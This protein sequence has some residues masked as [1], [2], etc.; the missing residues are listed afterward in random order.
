M[1]GISKD[2]NVAGGVSI[3]ERKTPYSASAV[4]LIRR[5]ARS[6]TALVIVGFVGICVAT[7]LAARSRDSE[8]R[9]TSWT[10]AISSLSIA[11]DRLVEVV[12]DH[13]SRHPGPQEDPDQTRSLLGDAPHRVYSIDHVFVFDRDGT[14]VFQSHAPEATSYK[15]FDQ[16]HV[17]EALAPLV[18][19][20]RAAANTSA[21]TA[22]VW[23]IRIFGRVHLAGAAAIQADGTKDAAPDN[24]GSVL[25]F[26][27][28]FLPSY[29]DRI[30]GR[31]ALRGLRIA[32]APNVS[33]NELALPLR[34]RDP[35]ET[36]GY[37]IWQPRLPGNA[38]INAIITPLLMT[39]AL[40]LVLL[41]LVLRWAKRVGASLDSASAEVAT[42]R[43]SLEAE[44][45]VRNA[46]LREAEARYRGIV[47]NAVEGI[48]QL[49][50]SGRFISANPAMARILGYADPNQLIAKAHANVMLNAT[51]RE[52]FERVIATF[53]EVVDF[54]SEVHRRDGSRT[55]ISQNTRAVRDKAGSIAYYEGTVVDIT[56]R[57]EAEENLIKN[58]F[59]DA[60]TGLPNRFLFFERLNQLI[61]RG[62]RSPD[63]AFA[64]LFLDC[65]RFKL[66][67]DS[68]GH[69]AGDNLLITLAQRL[70]QRLRPA[71]TLARLGG[72][73]F[74]ILIE[75][76][77]MPTNALAFA[78]RLHEACHQ[79]MKLE[80]RDVYV[81]ISIGIAFA[82][83]GRYSEA[84]AILRDADIAMYKAKDAGRGT[85]VLFEPGM[86]QA[87][88]SRLEVE[89]QLRH[90]LDRGG[91]VVYYQ[92]IISLKDHRVAGF[93][94]LVRW[95]HLTRGLVLPSEFIPTAEET[96]MIVPIGN[97]VLREACAFAASWRRYHGAAANNLFMSVNVS[98]AQLH[99][100]G[101]AG[102]IAETLSWSGLPG[103]NLKLEITESTMMANPL[104]VHRTLTDIAALGVRLCVD[105]FGT[106]YSS[107]SHLHT[108]P[109]STLKI[110]RAFTSRL[111]AG[112]EHIE[113]AKT[114]LMLGQ[115]LGLTVIAEG[116]ETTI[117]R[118]WLQ[119]A[120][121]NYG[122]GYYFGAPMDY[123][124]ASAL[125]TAELKDECPSMM[126]ASSGFA[127]LN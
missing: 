28:G 47:E 51:T 35:P 3:I 6:V 64:V 124:S 21:P 83:P 92:P 120:G 99:Q 90:A 115:N 81:G 8:A 53:G 45:G 20:A 109:V 32:D 29:L 42:S 31:T 88:V 60:L 69:L 114:I 17:A 27:H 41:A 103:T 122:Q 2:A 22:A 66:I 1:R 104:E 73:E 26:M 13:A 77:A 19:W 65:D 101:A 111:A 95:S 18:A 117:Q 97:L 59:H 24:K 116:V 106:G 112:R 76:G 87:V 38:M 91:F 44:V 14:S 54:V 98:A 89:T 15:A 121:C 40:M 43:E 62:Q 78:E 102:R 105:D 57:R 85:T 46:D 67:N 25:V 49:A 9:K 93:E 72:D 56:A 4:E 10:N 30:A 11:S 16:Q 58:A 79:P 126:R 71:D 48:F 12:T 50:P 82:H 68:F 75:G 23:P 52:A 118:D 61:V 80:G 36:V 125:L 107:L 7:V 37:L 63:A 34:S 86:H 110:D 5:I 108:F 123:R 33:N 55:W 119:A 70:S 96:G 113:M 74:A 100:P 94:A 84:D 39:A 127:I